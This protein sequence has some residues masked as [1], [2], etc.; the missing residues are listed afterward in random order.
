M[1]NEQLEADILGDLSSISPVT[2]NCNY[3]CPKIESPVAS[4]NYTPPR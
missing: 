2:A 1:T 4:T 3:T